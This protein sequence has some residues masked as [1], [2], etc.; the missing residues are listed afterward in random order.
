MTDSS[1][2]YV[3]DTNVMVHQIRDDET[4]RRIKAQY[5][6]FLTET[7]PAYC[8]VSEGEIRSLAHQWEWGTG[9]VDAMLFLLEYLRRNLGGCPLIAESIL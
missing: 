2:A 9:Q 7:I 1:P 6:L 4:G 5:N 3:T 8:V